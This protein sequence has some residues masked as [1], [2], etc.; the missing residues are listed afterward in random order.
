M[1]YWWVEQFIDN[2]SFFP[3]LLQVTFFFLKTKTHGCCCIG[4]GIETNWLK[5]FWQKSKSHVL[6]E[7]KLPKFGFFLQLSQ[8]IVSFKAP[9]VSGCSWILV[10]SGL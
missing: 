6:Q 9:I 7:Y 1:L 5:Q 3:Q 8:I 4:W 2:F 10:S